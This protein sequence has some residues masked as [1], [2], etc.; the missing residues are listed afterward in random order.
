MKR[1]QT[2]LKKK[3]YDV[4]SIAPDA[5][6]YDAIHLMAEKAVGAL[7]VMDG[8]KLVGVISE[9]DYARKIILEG[10]S[11]EN[12]KISEIMSSEVITTGPDNRIEEC[13][14]IMTERRIRHLPVLDGNEVL[15]VISLGD[16]VKYI[17]AEQQFVI[18]QMERYING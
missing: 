17:I 12:T 3:G 13:M 18:E 8:Q 16:L 15:G 5:S 11:S 9:R 10:R 4:W 1:I 6:V 2:L 14:A 7:I